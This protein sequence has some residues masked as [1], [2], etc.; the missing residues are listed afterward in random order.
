M[1]TYT[2]IP[3][4]LKIGYFNTEPW[5]KKGLLSSCFF[6]TR[7]GHESGGINYS[8]DTLTSNWFDVEL[9]RITPAQSSEKGVEKS[10]LSVMTWSIKTHLLILGSFSLCSP[11]AFSPKGDGKSKAQPFLA[12]PSSRHYQNDRSTMADIQ[13][14]YSY[15]LQVPE[16]AILKLAIVKCFF[17]VLK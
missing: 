5:E 15:I 10:K 9:V 1:Q 14:W 4:V 12:K 16:W 2:A 6:C 13:P 7:A 11:E 3:V 8:T 17:L